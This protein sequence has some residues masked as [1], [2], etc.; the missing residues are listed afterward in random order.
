L[1]QNPEAT[2]NIS[3]TIWNSIV[4]NNDDSSVLKAPD[5]IHNVA[6]EETIPQRLMGI[7]FKVD[8]DF[9]NVVAEFSHVIQ[10]L[11]KFARKGKFPLNRYIVIRVVKSSDALLSNTFDHDPKTLY[12]Y[13]DF[14]SVIGT[15]GWEEFTQ[16]MAQRFFDKYKAKEYIPNVNSYLSGILSAQIKQFEKVRAKYDP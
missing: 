1:L 7:A 3:A 16:F 14:A 6:G 10:T 9:S 2:P 15:P 11:Y 8:P 13:F 12:C 4:S 5:A